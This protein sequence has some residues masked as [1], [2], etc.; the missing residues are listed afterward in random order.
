M[1]SLK[2]NL[3]KVECYLLR[4]KYEKYSVEPSHKE[5][6]EEEIVSAIRIPRSCISTMKQNLILV[7]DDFIQHAIVPMRITNVV[8]LKIGFLIIK[9]FSLIWSIFNMD[10]IE[11]TSES[12][13]LN[14]VY[15]AGLG[16]LVHTLTPS[17]MLHCEVSV[18]TY[19]L[20]M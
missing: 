4:V 3:C 15:T 14:D 9:R 10:T 13:S 18:H 16:G 11:Q 2:N 5:H 1:L 6:G 8:S 17:E 7:S 20:C 19:P 12:E